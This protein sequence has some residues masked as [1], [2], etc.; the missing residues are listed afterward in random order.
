MPN[1]L[2]LTLL[3]MFPPFQILGQ[4]VTLYLWLKLLYSLSQF[5]FKVKLASLITVNA[6]DGCPISKL[7]VLFIT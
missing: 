1:Y 3:C 5:K 2:L 7:P 4:L 6:W